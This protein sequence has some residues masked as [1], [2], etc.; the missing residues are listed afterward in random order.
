MTKLATLG[1]AIP[2]SVLA[3]GIFIPV[4]WLDTQ[5]ASLSQPEAT[6]RKCFCAAVCW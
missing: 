5:I 6:V 4:A 2:G 1:Y 3:V